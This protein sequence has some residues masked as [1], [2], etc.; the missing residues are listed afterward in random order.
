MEQLGCAAHRRDD[1]E[2][3]RFEQADEAVAQQE[4]VLPDHDAHKT[5]IAVSMKSSPGL[6][7]R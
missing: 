5:S 3:V 4:E 7:L 1:L 2:A 6:V